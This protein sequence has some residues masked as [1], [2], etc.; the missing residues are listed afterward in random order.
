MSWIAA[1]IAGAGMVSSLVGGSKQ[2]K[3]NKAIAREQMA[4]QERM[5]NTQYQRGMADMRKAGLSP[6]LAYKQGGASVPTGAGIPAQNVL[7]TA[8]SSALN[9]YTQIKSAEN[10]EANTRLV[11][12]R[13]RLA[14]AEA[15][16]FERYGSSPV[17]TLAHSMAQMGKTVKRGTK[18]LPATRRTRVEQIGRPRPGETAGEMFR[19][20]GREK[21]KW[22]RPPYQ[23]R[24][25]RPGEKLGDYFSPG[26]R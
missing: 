10:T 9:A 8:G 13:K 22:R 3:T 11:N 26:R 20:K 19:R 23:S 5:S 7:G 6:I 16:R 12:E 24:K 21:R 25:P 2:N 18:R 4:F 1:A 17:G 15:D 14:S